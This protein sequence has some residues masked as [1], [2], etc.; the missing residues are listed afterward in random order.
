MKFK[1]WHHGTLGW[2]SDPETLNPEAVKDELEEGAFKVRRFDAA[3]PVV[4]HTWIGDKVVV[5]FKPAGEERIEGRIL[6]RREYEAIGCN[7]FEV[8]ENELGMER[9]EA[10]HGEGSGTEPKKVLQAGYLQAARWHFERLAPGERNKPYLSAL[11]DGLRAEDFP[12]SRF[13]LER[14]KAERAPPPKG[15]A[16]AWQWTEDTEEV[17]EE[18]H[19][20]PGLP[21]EP[22]TRES[23]ERDG[24]N[25][26]REPERAI[27]AGRENETPRRSGQEF[28]SGADE[29]KRKPVGNEKRE[30]NE[31]SEGFE[32]WWSHRVVRSG[33]IVV[34]A[35]VVSV[36]ASIAST[37]IALRSDIEATAQ[38][39]SRA[40][41]E[42]QMAWTAASEVRLRAQAMTEQRLTGRLEKAARETVKGEMRAALAGMVDEA[43]SE[44]ETLA[45]LAG[46]LTQRW[47][48]DV[49]A[50]AQG[51]IDGRIAQWDVEIERKV[52]N[53]VKGAV[54]DQLRKSFAGMLGA[55]LA[56][57][58]TLEG[59]AERWVACIAHR[60][61]K[62]IE[63]NNNRNAGGAGG[64][65]VTAM[66]RGQEQT[67]Q[68]W[69]GRR[70][71]G[72][73]QGE[74]AGAGIHEAS[75]SGSAPVMEGIRDH[76]A[77]GTHPGDM[78]RERRALT[79]PGCRNVQ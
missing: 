46:K 15:A 39:A 35:V 1:W 48:R 49:G 24:A 50:R 57:G 69:A 64:A 78:R 52:G 20:T 44:G 34:A 62:L 59:L 42:A 37:R 25:R 66:K 79:E 76:G 22:G 60:A 21:T 11:P 63:K 9:V 3:L 7:P 31:E 29:R 54:E 77:H 68:E 65:G 67:G 17:P 18:G 10:R 38:N 33:L 51:A 70:T 28:A 55:R 30:R 74:G 58:D 4:G 12:H 2:R 26:D 45:D 75:D 61:Q 71:G 13:R 36:V 5:G 16:S 72:E 73:V 8:A 41:E 43:S 27:R 53:E 23:L 32:S 19:R 40:A 14:T 47:A 56:E 6:S